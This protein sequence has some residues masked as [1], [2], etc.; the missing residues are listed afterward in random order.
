MKYKKSEAGNYI[1]PMGRNS[2]KTTEK[3]CVGELCA[4][5]IATSYLD[6][7]GIPQLSATEGTC[8][9]GINI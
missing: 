1:C 8:G 6:S 5:F 3:K 4:V 9:M 7:N 2:D